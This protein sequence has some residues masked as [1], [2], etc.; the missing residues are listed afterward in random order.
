MN[1][2]KDPCTLALETDEVLMNIHN[3]Y[4]ANLVEMGYDRADCEMVAAVGRDATYPRTIYGRTFDTKAEYDE[5]LADYLN[6]L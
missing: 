4:V 2:F 5:A 6:G 1:K 3:P